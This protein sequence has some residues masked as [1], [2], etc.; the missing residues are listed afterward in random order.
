MIYSK[1]EVSRFIQ[2]N[3]DEKYKE[4]HSRLTKT[5][6]KINGVRVPVL[7]KYASMLAKCENIEEFFS[8]KIQSYEECMLKGLTIAA[9][10]CSE[11][12]RYMF[13]EKFFKEIDDWAV[14]D[15]SCSKLKHKSDKYWQKCREYAASEHVWTARWGIVGIMTNFADRGD[16]IAW[17]VASVNAESYYIDM[18]LAWL[19]QVLAVKDRKVA[20]TIVK[21]QSVSSTVKKYALRKIKDSFRISIEDKQYFEKLLAE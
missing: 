21:S 1:E 5:A 19:L 3:S 15:V 6:Y 8:S 16:E 13:L 17:A 2:E 10:K 18:G 11:D 9:Y 7:R 14:C 20:E 12:R 4:F